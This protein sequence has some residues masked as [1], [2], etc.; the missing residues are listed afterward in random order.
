MRQDQCYWWLGC[1]G[2]KSDPV[3]DYNETLENSKK[4]FKHCEKIS[5][6]TKWTLTS[7]ETYLELNYAVG[8]EWSSF[9]GYCTGKTDIS[10]T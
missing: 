7:E 8:F 5:R 2:K 4:M 9:S 10:G 3:R 1:H 6:S